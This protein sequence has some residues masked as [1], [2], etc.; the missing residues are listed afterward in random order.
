[1]LATSEKGSKMTWLQEIDDLLW[2]EVK[3][4]RSAFPTKV[5]CEAEKENPFPFEVTLKR[6]LLKQSNLHF[7]KPIHYNR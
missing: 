6:P 1:M 7:F 5:L 4:D 3:L 2:R